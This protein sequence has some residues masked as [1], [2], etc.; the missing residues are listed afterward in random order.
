MP[1]LQEI[2]SIAG[3]HRTTVSMALKNHPRIPEETRQRIQT[4]AA[5]LGY[6]P[7]PYLSAWMTSVR[8]GKPK[9]GSGSIA[10]LSEFPKEV[11]IAHHRYAKRFYE[12]ARLRA[13]QLG[14]GLDFFS[15]QTPAECQQVEKV[16]R[17]R[18]IEGI[19]LA[20][21]SPDRPEIA[22]NWERYAGVIIGYELAGLLYPRVNSDQIRNMEIIFE[23]LVRRGYQRP[24]LVVFDNGLSKAGRRFRMAFN[25]MIHINRE[26][27]HVPILWP[28]AK[29]GEKA[30]KEN[31]WRWIERTRP[32]CI[33]GPQQE[34][35]LW[36]EEIGM[37][38]PDDIGIVCYTI[39]DESNRISGM[40][41]N[42]ESI[43][44]NAVDIVDGQLRRNE[45][46]IRPAHRLT[47][48]CGRWHEGDT[49]RPAA[50]APHST[51]PEK[52]PTKR[53]SR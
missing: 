25:D 45:R 14:Y 28:G 1:T 53:K 9:L 2:A 10:Y 11:L 38:T 52:S 7:N 40:I 42:F 16:L 24:G 15:P 31:L 18:S 49:L 30:A 6:K 34:I 50:K 41:E 37:K 51:R 44:S 22:L 3:V 23:E 21:F 39:N 26:L 29:I 8:Q 27:A 36:L 19:I 43:G 48:Q 5:T 46:G 35:P 17:A 33:I 20:Y 13:E 4:I 12:G 47:V 32:D